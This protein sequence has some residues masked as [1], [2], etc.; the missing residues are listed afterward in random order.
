MEKNVFQGDFELPQPLPISRDVGDEAVALFFAHWNEK[1]YASQGE[2]AIRGFDYI[3]PVYDHDV[4]KAGP[5]PEIIH[6]IG[7][8]ALGN[9][10]GAPHLL[11]EARQKQVQVLRR[12][13]QQLQDPTTALSDSSILTCT[14]LSLFEVRNPSL[15]SSGDANS[16]AE[17]YLRATVDA[18]HGISPQGCFDTC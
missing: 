11:M 13:N 4:R 10:N 8:A 3:R 2:N 1:F 6:A 14:L 16:F 12:L 7:L 18:G 15:A 17:C 9:T 5:V